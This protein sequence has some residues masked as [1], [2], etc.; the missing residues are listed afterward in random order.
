LRFATPVEFFRALS[1]GISGRS[2]HR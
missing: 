2:L 1:Q